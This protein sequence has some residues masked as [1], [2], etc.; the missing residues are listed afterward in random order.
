[1]LYISHLGISKYYTCNHPAVAQVC[2]FSGLDMSGSDPLRTLVHLLPRM[3]SLGFPSAKARG[4]SHIYHTDISACG[5]IDCRVQKCK[6]V[7]T[8]G[9]E[10]LPFGSYNLPHC[11]IVHTLYL[12]TAVYC[13]KC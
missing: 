6:W 7:A 8:Q 1:M 3:N 9:H 5:F 11:M 12:F 13:G 10:N 2:H 4:D